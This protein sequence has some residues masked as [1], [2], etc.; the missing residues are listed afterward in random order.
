MAESTTIR[1]QRQFAAHLR[2][3][4]QPPP[5]DVPVRRMTLYAELA[6]A[7]IRG[8]VTPNFPV[9]RRLYDDDG[10]ESLL[11]G[12]MREHRCRTP[13][14]TQFPAE[15]VAYLQQRTALALEPPYVAELAHY[16]WMESALRLSDVADVRGDVDPDGDLLA[17]SPV[18]SALAWPVSYRFPVHRIAPDFRPD[19]A[20]PVPTWLLLHRDDGDDVRFIEINAVSAR[21]LQLVGECT[22]QCGAELL[23]QIATEIG[24]EEI[25]PVIAAGAAQLAEWRDLGI[26]LGTR[27]PSPDAKSGYLPVE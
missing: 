1:L 12:F 5:P 17:G 9:L 7:N 19:V 8:L 13:L 20:P 11:R 23:R 10:W 16:E 3:P 6:I 27:M 15:F 2:D 22:G 24:R 26:I 14:F 25:E 21:L 18:L 4:T